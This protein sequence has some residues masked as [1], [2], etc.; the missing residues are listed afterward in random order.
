VG[1]CPYLWKYRDQGVNFCGPP[2]LLVKRRGD[3]PMISDA[4]YYL[5]TTLNRLRQKPVLTAMMV[6]SL[7]FGAT[8]LMAGVVV[9]RVNSNCSIEASSGLSN[10]GR[11]VTDS[12]GHSDLWIDHQALQA[13]LGVKVS[14]PSPS[15]SALSHKDARAVCPCSALLQLQR[16]RPTWQ[17]I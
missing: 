7:V 8:A 15:G 2:V 5:H 12:P 3:L 4:A 13:E 14:Q 9:W 6:S 16:A 11:L 1:S 17:R 10:V